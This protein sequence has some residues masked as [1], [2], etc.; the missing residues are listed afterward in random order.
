ML[1][2]CINC[3]YLHLSLYFPILVSVYLSAPV[4]HGLAEAQTGE[5]ARR[6]PLSKC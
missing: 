6:A 4:H 1:V 5:D 3:H 2:S